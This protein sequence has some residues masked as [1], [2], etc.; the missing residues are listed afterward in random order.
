MLH[1]VYNLKS[2]LRI[3][4]YWTLRFSTDILTVIETHKLF[5]MVRDAANAEGRIGDET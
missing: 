5:K 4:K 2:I 1:L 3:I